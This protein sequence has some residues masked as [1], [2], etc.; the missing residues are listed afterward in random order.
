MSSQHPAQHTA[1][2]SQLFNGQ[3]DAD[4]RLAGFWGLGRNISL[5]LALSALFE[6]E[7]RVCISCKAPKSGNLGILL[8][9]LLWQLSRVPQGEATAAELSLD[10]E[11]LPH[12]I[13]AAGPRPGELGAGV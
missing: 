5:Y 2:A 6:G 13:P 3:T 7:T 8:I 1:G 12:P 4:G 10:K 9:P 11:F